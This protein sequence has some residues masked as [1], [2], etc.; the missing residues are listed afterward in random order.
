MY[1]KFL[2]PIIIVFAK[3]L[4]A[5]PTNTS[6][7]KQALVVFGDS[8]S[9]N[10]H[11]RNSKYQGGRS[12]NGNTWNEYLSNKLHATLYNYAWGGATADNLKYYEKA[13]VPRSTVSVKEAVDLF[14]RGAYDGVSS[15]SLNWDP[16]NTLFAVWIGVNDN[17]DIFFHAYDSIK[18]R[19]SVDAVRDS[20]ISLYEHG[21]R[22]FLLLNVPPLEHMPYAVASSANNSVI[23]DVFAECVIVYNMML[24]EMS[25][26]FTRDNPDIKLTYYDAHKQFLSFFE[27]NT[28][29][30]LADP[31]T[32]GRG[33]CADPDTYLYWDTWHITSK[34]SH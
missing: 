24:A 16:A 2:F 7:S 34:N 33:T 8:Y 22:Q 10:G 23:L 30:N 17:T 11:P 3:L 32:T 5:A 26:D 15:T 18:Y 14:Y 9:D 1:C 21:A 27:N 20:L 28:F 12:T 31:C 25:R 6:D 13:I 19:Q 4:Q 29:K